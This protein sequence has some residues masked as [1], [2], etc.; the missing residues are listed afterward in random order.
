[1]AQDCRTVSSILPD[2]IERLNQAV[3]NL[4]AAKQSELTMRDHCN[5]LRESADNLSIEQEEDIN[6]YIRDS[7]QTRINA[8]NDLLQIRTEFQ[9]VARQL[10][11]ITEIL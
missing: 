11:I 6:R 2:I 4:E 1:M 3:V 7:I 5:L 9:T 10:L 8:E